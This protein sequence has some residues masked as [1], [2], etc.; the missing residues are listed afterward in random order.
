M[1]PNALHRPPASTTVAEFLAWPGDGTGR[2][3]QLIDGEVR[4]AS[5][6]RETMWSDRAIPS[7]PEIAPIHAAR[8]QTEVLRRRPDG[9]WPEALDKI[10]E[11]ETLAFERTGCANPLLDIYAETSIGTEDQA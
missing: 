9:Q 3:C 10:I 11:G 1:M 7:V 8:V 2:K 4:N 5:E 6:T